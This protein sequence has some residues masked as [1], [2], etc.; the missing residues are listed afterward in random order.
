MEEGSPWSGVL[1][2]AKEAARLAG[3]QIRLAWTQRSEVK[4][5]KSNATDLVTETDQRCEDIVMGLLRS[6]FP[7]HQIIGEE[8]SGSSKY[9]LTDA[10]TWTIDP[11]DG[12]TNFVHRLALSCVIIA[13][14]TEKQVR[15]GLVYDPMADEMFWAT[16]GGGAF[17]ESPR[18]SAKT[19]VHVS[20]T[21]SVPR[22]VI[23]MDPGY[24]RNEDAVDA[25]STVQ[26]AILLKGVRNIRV[27]G[28]TGLNMAYVA[29]G[30]FDAGF[31]QG[32]WEKNIGPKI[33]DFAA[34]KL[35]V[36]EAG[37]VTRDL[38][39]PMP[40]DNGLDLMGRSFFCAATKEL[41]KEL[42]E[43]ISSKGDSTEAP[44]AKKQ[45]K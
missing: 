1:D 34:G 16:Q 14:L 3:E 23:S 43:L 10:P 37:G 28:S 17:L 25:F 39:E 22:A 9:E 30:R 20:N 32:S 42:L 44:P 5:T 15:M 7:T 8:S 11:I 29:S 41:A 36:E 27:L 24:G 12:T 31:E 13:H 2:V 35:I 38:W 21:T 18:L 40:T 26:R 4:D 19:Q 45:R 6:K 33:W